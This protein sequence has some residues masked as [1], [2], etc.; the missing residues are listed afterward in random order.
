[1]KVLLIEDEVAHCDKYVK[2]TENLPYTVELSVA[3][4]LKKSINLADDGGFK[5]ILLDLELN[6]S[7]GDGIAFLQWLKTAKLKHRPFIIVITNNRSKATH[8]IV[9]NLGADYIFMKMKPD[10]SPRLVF[11]FALN[12]L[13][14]QPQEEKEQNDSLENAVAREVEKIGF[15]HDVIGTTYLI[16]A[17]LTVLYAGKAK[18]SMDRDVYPVI[19]KKFKK[20]DWSV[21]RAIRTAIVRTWRM[22]D[23]DTLVENYTTNIDFDLGYP[24]NKQMVLTIAEKI[25]RVSGGAA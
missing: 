25:K 11:D 14:S 13:K 20:T 1:M 6:E 17:I 23:I 9:R 3:N 12:C 5:I 16:H 24:T 21:S 19:A 22:T 18:I 7:D 4:G 8:N 15:T 2:C 10:Y